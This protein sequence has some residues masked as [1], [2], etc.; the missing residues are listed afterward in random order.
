MN[1]R[2][3]LHR[4]VLENQVRVR[5][6]KAGGSGTVI[7]SLPQ[8]EG[9]EYH[10]Y[11][12]TCHHVIES[13]IEV[14]EA[15]DSRVGRQRKREYRQLVT[16][17]FF[18]WSNVPH[19]HRPLTYSADAEVVAYDSTH[20]MAL[21]RLRTL[22]AAPAVA[23]VPT[24]GSERALAI[25]SPVVAV[26]CALLHDPIMTSGYI[27]H[28]GD[29]IDYKL[30]W[31]SNAATVF[32]NSGGAVFAEFAATADRPG[33]YRFVG[34]PSRIDIAGWGSPI[35]HLGYFSPITRIYEFLDEQLYHF[36]IPGHEHTEA[37]CEEERRERKESEDRR[38]QME[39]P[40][41][42]S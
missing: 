1:D 19:G 18:D 16:T 10:T 35:T 41:Q 7:A 22:K 2:E 9:G 3:Q 30:Y 23:A 26:G 20:D 12:I 28:M 11:A 29:E 36:L 13:A 33:S 14:K 37:R 4:E 42:D 32:G 34:I 15:W 21:L 24:P 6:P 8:P 40:E 38:L 27:T 5:T 25:G 31:M 39:R 17:E